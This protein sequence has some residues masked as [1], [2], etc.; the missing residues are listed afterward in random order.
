MSVAF[1]LAAIKGVCAL[2]LFIVFCHAPTHRMHACHM[3]SKA[4]G[5]PSSKVFTKNKCDSMLRLRLKLRYGNKKRKT[6][7]KKKTKNKGREEGK[8][9]KGKQKKK[10]STVGKIKNRSGVCSEE[11][12]EGRGASGEKAEGPELTLL[13]PLHLTSVSFGASRSAWTFL[14]NCFVVEMDGFKG[15]PFSWRR[16]VSGWAGRARRGGG[17]GPSFCRFRG[18]E[19]W[20]GTHT[21]AHR[22]PQ[23]LTQLHKTHTCRHLGTSMGM[24]SSMGNGIRHWQLIK[25]LKFHVNL[26][27]NFDK[28]F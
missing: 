6:W 4:V 25:I 11:R 5:L 24:D 17:R 2:S 28:H 13:V 12:E 10:H 8:R 20:A 22:Q 27:L 15:L 9:E 1:F 7:N 26:N 3:R 21:Q 16:W 14:K 23:R 18:P 19:P